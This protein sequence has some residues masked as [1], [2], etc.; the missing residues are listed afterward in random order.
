MVYD[1]NCKHF[2]APQDMCNITIFTGKFHYLLSCQ[3]PPR[4]FRSKYSEPWKTDIEA[5]ES[6]GCPCRCQKLT[7]IMASCWANR[8][9]WRSDFSQQK[10]RAEDG[11]GTVLCVF[12]HPILLFSQLF[13]D[14][15]D[16]LTHVCTS[17]AGE[18]SGS[19]F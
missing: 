4:G 18:A 3:L 2:A 13:Q 5:G 8:M 14:V 12:L 7:A 1:H 15:G 11:V 9:V 6:S 16:I 17:E 10:I 19:E